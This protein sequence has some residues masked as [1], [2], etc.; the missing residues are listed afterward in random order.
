MATRRARDLGLHPSIE[1]R[2]SRVAR[3]SGALRFPRRAA[4]REIRSSRR[5]G[6]SRR[7]DH[8]R[9][10]GS[11]SF[12]GHDTAETALIWCEGRDLNASEVPIFTGDHE[13]IGEPSQRM[14]TP[15]KTLPAGVHTAA[16][17]TLAAKARLLER[18]LGGDER[19]LAGEL[20]RGLEALAG[21]SAEILPLAGRHRR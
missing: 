9:A 8:Q 2:R 4:R 12:R 6:A 21:P 3:R 5:F 7:C 15:P 13:G 18:L 17:A 1:G 20:V 11:V 16:L 14:A 19:L 10:S